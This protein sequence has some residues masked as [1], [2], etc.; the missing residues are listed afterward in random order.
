MFRQF[1]KIHSIESGINCY[2]Y[3]YTAHTNKHQKHSQHDARHLWDH[4]NPSEYL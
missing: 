1:T 3:K 4:K 2:R